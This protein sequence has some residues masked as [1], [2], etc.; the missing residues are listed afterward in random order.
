MRGLP[1]V[2]KWQCSPGPVQRSGTH[3]QGKRQGHFW[4]VQLAW[5]GGAMWSI[6]I[7]VT[8]SLAGLNLRPS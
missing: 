7:T 5:V 1:A 4:R 2:N 6:A 8:G 3:R